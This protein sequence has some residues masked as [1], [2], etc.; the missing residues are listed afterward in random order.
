MHYIRIKDRIM[1]QQD[2]SIFCSIEA[3]EKIKSQFHD[4]KD[5]DVKRTTEVL[6]EAIGVVEQC[7]QT[8]GNNHS[9]TVELYYMIGVMYYDLKNYSQSVKWF[10]KGANHGDEA[11]ECE[12]ALM[13]QLGIGVVQDLT[14]AIDLYTRAAEKGN[15]AAMFELGMIFENAEG[16]KTDYARAAEW[17]IKLVTKGDEL[18]CIHLAWCLH[19]SGENKKA[20]T[21]AQRNAKNNPDDNFVIYTLAC[22]YQALGNKEKA[23]KNF[24][25]CLKLEEEQE[26]SDDIKS[27]TRQRIME[28]NPEY[29][30]LTFFLKKLPIKLDFKTI[31]MMV[32][33]G[34]ITYKKT[35]NWGDTFVILLK[36]YI[37]LS[38][39]VVMLP[40]VLSFFNKLGECKLKFWEIPWKTWRKFIW[41]N[42]GTWGIFIVILPFE[43]LLLLC[44]VLS[45]LCIIILVTTIWI[46]RHL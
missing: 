39:F 4:I 18:A 7:I 33:I 22:I 13:Y 27:E 42:I 41:V 8:L 37:V 12:L 46:N 24:E 43:I 29:T 23:L 45:V 6:I 11:S 30:P 20:L 31:I 28:L 35:D 25:L 32:L 2:E 1:K 36:V 21:W 17:Y 9:H 10:T 19:M 14:K 3:F 5:G 26:V 40:S 38:V 34:W 15:E 44:I 16:V